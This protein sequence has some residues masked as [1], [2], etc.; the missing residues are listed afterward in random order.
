MALKQ[1]MNVNAGNL[2]GLLFQGE[3]N[4]DLISEKS[5][6]TAFVLEHGEN[7]NLGALLRENAHSFGQKIH[8]RPHHQTD[9]DAV[10]VFRAE[11][12]PLLDSTLEVLPHGCEKSHKLGA[13]RREYRA[14]ACPLKNRKSDFLFKEFNLVRKSRL[15]DKKIVRRPAEVQR[16]CN[17]YTVIDLFGG[18]GW[19]LFF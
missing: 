3:Q 6:D 12:L 1:I 17:F 18:H 10:L 4:I 13:G 15:A 2:L 19:F 8:C 5:L 16:V 9:G 14:L 7:L 11:V